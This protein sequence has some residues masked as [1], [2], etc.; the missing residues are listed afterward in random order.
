MGCRV[1]RLNIQAQ[2]KQLLR[3]SDAVTAMGKA[4]LGGSLRAA[5][6][7]WGAG[8]DAPPPA[9]SQPPGLQGAWAVRQQ[10][11]ELQ[12]VTDAR[13][14]ALDSRLLG[15]P[16]PAGA[17]PPPPAA[18]RQQQPQQRQQHV[19]SDKDAASS[20]PAGAPGGKPG[21]PRRIAPAPAGAP[22]V[23]EQHHLTQACGS[24]A[25]QPAR[26]T[27]PPSQHQQQQQQA[28][29]LQSG[30]DRATAKLSRAAPAPAS[31]ISTSVPRHAERQHDAHLT[32]T[33]KAHAADAALP[34][35]RP[36]PHNTP[37][38]PFATSAAQ[39]PGLLPPRPAAA[40][41]GQP[42][43]TPP[44]APA[45]S[46]T[47]PPAAA[48]AAAQAAA[49]PTASLA[50]QRLADHL[51]R[52]HFK[53]S[54]VEDLTRLLLQLLAPP[55]ARATSAAAALEEG[56]GAAAPA[57]KP[58]A[59][60]GVQR[61]AGGVTPR[62]GTPGMAAAV[63]AAQVLDRCAPLVSMEA[64]ASGINKMRHRPRHAASKDQQLVPAQTRV[65][66]RRL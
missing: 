38:S 3:R 35:T 49:P 17:G 62:H 5:A 13:Q 19:K 33:G 61:P 21:P 4:E 10:K 53:V 39:L 44:P 26:I 30:E 12:G 11:S 18:Q 59:Q 60:Q 50:A 40:P 7:V 47:P 25:W 20:T 24:H 55:P 29:T 28:A 45:P 56:P 64:C 36:A 46:R 63:Q 43:R 22:T 14:R 57:D 54:L 16:L 51:M 31:T 8:S 34:A 15:V 58:A 1:A 32:P 65:W 52:G 23:T 6:G 48:A 66:W 37:I 27:S 9:V 41:T 2:E 42:P